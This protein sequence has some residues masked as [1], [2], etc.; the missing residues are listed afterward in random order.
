[1]LQERLKKWQK[2]QKKGNIKL[3]FLCDIAGQGP[4]IITA[5]AVVAALVSVQSLGQ[6]LPNAMVVAKKMK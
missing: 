3:E 5:V 4:D 1:M 6:E 2:D